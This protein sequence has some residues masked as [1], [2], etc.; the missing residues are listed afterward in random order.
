MIGAGLAGSLVA[1]ESARFSEVTVLEIGP[2]NSTL[3][4]PVRFTNKKLAEVN[5]FCFGAGGSTNLWH[6]G[7]VPIRPSD[8]S[9][10][11]FRG[12]L[13]DLI[14]FTDP[15][16]AAL[17]FDQGLFSS[18][19]ARVLVEMNQI[20]E[21]LGFGKDRFDCLIYPKRFKPLGL[22][23]SVKAYYEVERIEFLAHEGRITSLQIHRGGQRHTLDADVIVVS[24]GTMGTSRVLDRLL[25]AA[26]QSSSELGTGFM[27]HP[28]GFV[29]KVRLKPEFSRA[30][31][32]LSCLD[33]GRYTAQGIMRIRSGCGSY[34]CGV[35]FRPALTMENRLGIHRFKSSLGASAG[36]RRLRNALSL[37]L[38]HP[39]IVAEIVAHLLHRRLP[40]RTYGLLLV[41][42]QK[43]GRN[44]VYYEGGDL[45][46]DW[47]VTEEE[48]KGYRSVLAQLRECLEPVAEEIVLKDELTE[49][50]LWSCAHHSGA[51]PMGTGEGSLIDQDLR[52]RL[53]DNVYVCDGSVIQEHSYANTGL[54]IG[55]LAFRLVERIHGQEPGS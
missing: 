23:S 26:G 36:T 6:N 11:T 43:Q 24:A 15:V 21:S 17:F 3:F 35:F 45:V 29:G 5:T 31:R 52:L 7:L 18:E 30:M 4:P 10:I 14:R 22:D 53:F 12:V 8:V 44:R 34:M 28:M 25:A 1:N 27:D 42:E 16:A 55:Q 50:W 47:T 48:L 20:A 41:A 19:Y 38:F 9:G 49:E 2:R 32:R 54:T 46:V 33:R 13:S 37:N 51:T 40:S 39:D